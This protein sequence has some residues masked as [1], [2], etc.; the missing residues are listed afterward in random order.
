MA[1][2]NKPVAQVQSGGRLLSTRKKLARAKLKLVV[3]QSA[4]VSLH[5]FFRVGPGEEGT[6]QETHL[7]GFLYKANSHW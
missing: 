1:D 4:N 7:V 5:F 6:R 3:V 2:E